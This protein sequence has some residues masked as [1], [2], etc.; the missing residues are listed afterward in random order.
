MRAHTRGTARST[1]TRGDGEQRPI[2]IFMTPPPPTFVLGDDGGVEDL[3][4][5]EGDGQR[6]AAAHAQTDRRGSLGGACAKHKTSFSNAFFF[7]Q[8]DTL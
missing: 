3:R 2:T 4:L 1:Q 5:L 8:C 6:G 7:K